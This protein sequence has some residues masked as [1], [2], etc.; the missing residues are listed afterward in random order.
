MTPRQ[1][2][3]YDA[4]QPVRDYVNPIYEKALREA[5]ATL[6][7]HRSWELY[8]QELAP[9]KAWKRSVWQNWWRCYPWVN[10]VPKPE[11]PPKK[12]AGL[13]ADLVSETHEK[14]VNPYNPHKK[15]WG[16]RRAR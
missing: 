16:Y 7:D 1:Q 15:I 2:A 3:V 4:I 11:A 6:L 8:D 14:S 5:G 10:P 13:P 12:E 9:A